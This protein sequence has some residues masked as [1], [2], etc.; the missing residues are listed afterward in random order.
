MATPYLRVHFNEGANAE[1]KVRKNRPWKLEKIISLKGNLYPGFEK[2]DRHQ[3]FL[4]QGLKVG[5]TRQVYLVLKCL[6]LPKKIGI[7]SFSKGLHLC[8]LALA[9]WIIACFLK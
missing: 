9:T 3:V 7:L 6:H 5:L 4:P 1:V 8:Q 2:R